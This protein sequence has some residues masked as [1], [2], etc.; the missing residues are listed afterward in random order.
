MRRGQDHIKKDKRILGESEF[1]QF[2]LDS[3]KRNEKI[4]KA[5]QL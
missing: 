2:V 4:A 5:E 3:V 1:I